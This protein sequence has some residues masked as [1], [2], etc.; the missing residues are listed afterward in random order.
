MRGS[1]GQ[2][3]RR[4]RASFILPIILFIRG[5]LGIMRLMAREG[6]SGLMAR[7][8]TGHGSI[9]KCVAKAN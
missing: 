3:R 1:I 9:T 2:A 4:A 5:S 6:M 7:F 8:I